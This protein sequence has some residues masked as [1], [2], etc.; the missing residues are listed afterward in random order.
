M[1]DKWMKKRMYEDGLFS[2]GYPFP[3]ERLRDALLKSY[4]QQQQR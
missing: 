4:L 3:V 1:T 2:Y